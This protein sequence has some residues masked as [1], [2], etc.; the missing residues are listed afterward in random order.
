MIFEKV[1]SILVEEFGIDEEAVTSE[2]DLA[3]DLDIDDIDLVDLVMSL[4]DEFEIELSDETI[5]HF[6]TVGDF[7]KYIEEH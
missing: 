3:N 6:S 7:V 4:E 5:E 2:A 1:K